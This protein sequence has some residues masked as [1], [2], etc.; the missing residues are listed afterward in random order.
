VWGKA[1]STPVLLSEVE[2][3]R[4]GFAIEGGA[5]QDRAGSSVA[6]AGDV[7]RDG[8]LDLLI[9]ASGASVAGDG[10]GLCHVLFGWDANEAVGA[11]DGALIGSRADDTL[12]FA[13]TPFISAVGGNGI[14]TLAFDGAGLS[15]D[16]R[17]RALRVESIEIVDVRGSG[18]NTL[19]L[20][21]AAVRRLPQTRAGLPA[22]M[23]KTLIVLADAG[24]TVRFDAAG[25]EIIGSNAGR[26]VYR[27]TDASYGI[28]ISPG[29]T[30]SAP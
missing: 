11:R 9:G 19:V 20:D 24:D 17:D 18:D 4:G 29:V 16:V 22:G 21:D 26:D 3:E 27:K 14:D 6:G 15:L 30:L 13:G 23:A 25:Y 10:A 7:D 8:M 12:T 2:A 28:E 5:E 1:S